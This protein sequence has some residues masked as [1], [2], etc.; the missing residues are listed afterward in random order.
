MTRSMSRFAILAALLGSSMLAGCSQPEDIPGLLETR[1]IAEQGL[2]YGLPIVMNYT[3]MYSFTVDKDS[4]Q[5]KGPFNQ[6]KNTSKVL[7]YKDTAVV[8][9]NSDTP[10]SMIW[11]D[12]RAEPMVLSVPAIPL[13]RYYSLQP[14]DSSTYN[15]G[16]IGSRSTG[17]EAGNYLVVGPDWQGETPPGIRQ[18]FRSATPFSLVIYRTQLFDPADVDN[19]IEV[20][21]G[22]RAQPLSAFLQQAPVPAAPAVEFPKVDK[23][24]AKK[25]FFTYLDF[26]L[27]H[28]PAADNE[29]AI[30][31]QLARIG[32]GSDKAFAFNQLPWL[33][34]MA[35][36]WGMKRGNDQIEAAIASRGKR[37]NGWQVSSLA[38]DR[39]FYAGNWL[40]RA[41]V[42][43]AGIYANDAPEA[44][45]P[46]T[47]HLE[48]GQVLNTAKHR[49]SITFGADQLPP[50]NSFW[51]L[52]LYD[53]QTQL[54]I[55]NPL[56]RYLIN[57][58]ML[59]D[60]KKN[61]DGSITLL[62]QKDSP[63][64]EL[65]S[66]W[67]PAPD[68]EIYLVMRLYWPK[69]AAPSILP[70]GSG[71]WQPPAIARVQ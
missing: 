22:Y 19:L 70:A 27:Q 49:Y 66:N 68:A 7:T 25:D 29:K 15:Y 13:S 1:D 14:I 36:L 30:R 26:A 18:V 6:L 45:Y 5:Y 11:L 38:G 31:A 35:A 62:I 33:H 69:T 46:M 44:V 9:P 12:L 17:P 3:V 65:E 4:D 54:L 8:T 20:Q 51:S 52:T 10:Y 23:E 50:V 21:K 32:V 43:K 24:L 16:Y 47:R 55:Q 57:S 56:D 64:A 63:G 28:I 60:L 58:A 41:M 61:T 37:I 67:L 71:S 48:N 39:E 42:A 34:R 40:Q 59:P 53:S 2:I